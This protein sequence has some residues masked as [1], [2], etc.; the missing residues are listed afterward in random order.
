MHKFAATASGLMTSINV[1]MQ[2][3]SDIKVAI[4]ADDAG[5]PGALLAQY[6]GNWAVE[7]HI[8]HADRWVTVPLSTFVDVVEGTNYWLAYITDV[9]AVGINPVTTPVRY[10]DGQ[11]FRTYNFPNP[12]GSGYSS[13]AVGSC[14]QGFCIKPGDLLTA[15]DISASTLGGQWNDVPVPPIEVVAGVNYWLGVISERTL[16]CY[17]EPGLYANKYLKATTYDGFTFPGTLDISTGEI[18]EPGTPTLITMGCGALPGDHDLPCFDPD[19]RWKYIVIYRAG[20]EIFR[21]AA[22]AVE[23]FS[24]KDY[25]SCYIAAIEAIG[26]ISHIGLWGGQGCSATPGSGIELDKQVYVR[27]KTNLESLEV[28]FTENRW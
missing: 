21:K 5:E 7:G 8:A 10:L 16:A 26:A 14:I 12:A 9:D 23:H 6:S 11:T 25:A 3:E 13:M 27:E 22:L 24:D 28:V 2:I 1:Y 20:A 4:Y 19:D 18:S 15:N 17:P